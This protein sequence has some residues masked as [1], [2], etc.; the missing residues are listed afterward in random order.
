MNGVFFLATE[1][2]RS[3]GQ[4]VDAFPINGKFSLARSIFALTEYLQCEGQECHYSLK[5][6]Q[7]IAQ[8]HE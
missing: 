2:A 5:F 7:F 4:R 8:I 6:M 3:R 1:V